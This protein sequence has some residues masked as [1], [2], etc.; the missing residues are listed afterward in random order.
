MRTETAKITD[1]RKIAADTW[2]MVLKTSLAAETGC[3]Q[4]VQV[5]V[6]GYFLRRPISVCDVNGD[7]LTIVFRTV[8]KGT[9]ALSRIAPGEKI[10][11]LLE[12]GNGY[13]L[14]RA[15]EKPLLIGGG[16]GIPPLYYLAKKLSEEGKHVTALLGFN[17]AADVF[18]TDAFAEYAEVIVTTADGSVGV[19]GFVSDA[20]PEEYSFFYAC[21]PLPMEKALYRL[22]KTGGQFSLEERMACGFGA[23]MG[24][25]IKTKKGSQRVCR[26]GPVFDREDLLWD[27]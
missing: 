13:D 23:C 21:G 4:F 2:K 6:P 9:D 19:K 12:L 14:A 27:D 26:E 7:E 22:L 25:S 8:G 20:L 5:Q 15:G 24:C 18:Y 10:D 1:N 11:A 3:G 16:V 17:T